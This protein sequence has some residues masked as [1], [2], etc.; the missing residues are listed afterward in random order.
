MVTSAVQVSPAL[1]RYQLPG[2]DGVNDRS[3][4]SIWHETVFTKSNRFV[5]VFL[6]IAVVMYY[7]GS[8]QVNLTGTLAADRKN[9]SIVCLLIA[10]MHIVY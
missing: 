1:V 5:H 2:D 3:C 6:I 10:Q 4:S 9:E 8:Q 7:F